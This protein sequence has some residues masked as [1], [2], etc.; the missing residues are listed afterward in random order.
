MHADLIKA[1]CEEIIR[2]IKNQN[3]LLDELLETPDLLKESSEDEQQRTDIPTV[4]EWQKTINDEAQKVNELEMV[5]AVVGTMKA[6]KSTT[7]N[8]IVGSEI[9]PT[10]NH[11]M[12]S[13]PTLIR[14]E[15]G[16]K[17]PVLYFP[18]YQP[19]EEMVHKIKEKLSSLEKSNNLESVELY[20]D[21]DGKELIQSILEGNFHQFQD[22]YERQE[23]IFNFLKFLNDLMRLAIDSSI[24]V[25]FPIEEYEN[26]YDLP[27]IEVEFYHLANVTP[28]TIGKF[29]V[30]D[31][32]GPNELILGEKLREV[33]RKQIAKASAVL[34]VVDYGQL[35]SEAEGQ[36]RK[37]LLSQIEQTGDHL[38]I[39]VNQFD[40]RDRNGM[41]FEEV[42][43]YAAEIFLQGRITQERVYPVS[44]LHAYLSNRALNEIKGNGCLPD[45]RN[46]ENLWVEDFARLVLGVNWED[47]IQDIDK[48]RLNTEKLLKGSNFDQPINKVILKAANTAALISM[49]SATRKM[50][51]Y[52]KKLEDF[53]ELHR[54][55]LTKTVDYISQLIHGLAQDIEEVKNAETKADEALK[56]LIN[57]FL[58]AVPEEYEKVKQKLKTAL[59]DYFKEGKKQEK[60]ELDQKEQEILEGMKKQRRIRP[61]SLLTSI[62]EKI[63]NMQPR[64]RNDV[65]TYPLFNPNNPKIQF[66]S[67]TER[68][69]FLDKLNQTIKTI[70]FDCDIEL[71]LALINLSNSLEQTIHQT[72]T[73]GVGKI[74][75]NAK[76]RLQDEGF[77]LQFVVPELDIERNDIDFTGLLLSSIQTPSE[78]ILR[79]ESR[80]V[81]HWLGHVLRFFGGLFAQTDWGYETY[82]YPEKVYKFFVDMERIKKEVLTSFDSSIQKLNTNNTDLFDKTLKPLLDDYFN[83]LKDYLEKFRGDLKDSINNH[84]LDA[85]KYEE[86]KQRIIELKGRAELHKQDVQCIEQ[87]LQ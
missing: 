49:Q 70:I 29:A 82:E 16:K 37:E 46:K 69:E 47:N 32:P 66:E 68:K 31:T 43:R 11:P 39:L 36:I 58:E 19:I 3:A 30:L 20:K 23:N 87:N 86:L 7:I 34:A 60:Q 73:D 72:I 50:S 26:I 85:K 64:Y 17:E 33:L 22:R 1:T 80:E 8:A 63:E 51:H 65:Q 27:I 53:L 55:T 14:H 76:K 35:K 61:F 75:D 28:L 4:K 74:L 41:T 21:T 71:Q 81:Q 62:F 6:G 5:L 24:L 25:H 56:Q 84:N 79:P 40:R 44:A 48:V 9:L 13:L 18:K 42:K 59:E 52:G 45:Y 77:A 38:F 54:V 83:D 15:I 78:T 12:T 57:E 2:L 10:R 67:E